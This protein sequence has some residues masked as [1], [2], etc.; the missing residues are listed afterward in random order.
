MRMMTFHFGN[1]VPMGLLF[2]AWTVNSVGGSVHVHVLYDIDGHI[3]AYVHNLPI[4][5]QLQS[6]V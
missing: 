5:D 3:E 1:S 2:R 4:L 6:F